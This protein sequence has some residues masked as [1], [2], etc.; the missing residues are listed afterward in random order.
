MLCVFRARARAPTQSDDG[1]TVELLSPPDGVP[2]GE[3]L[4]VEGLGEPRPDAVL[5]SDGQQKAVKRFL[6][7]LRINADREGTAD[8]QRLLTSAGPCTVASLSDAK[9]R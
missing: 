9:L 1:A 7:S 4:N 3:R 8:G 5:K 6:A 2:V